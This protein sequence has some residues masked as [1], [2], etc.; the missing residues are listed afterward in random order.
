MARRTNSG[1]QSG[2]HR[3]LRVGEAI[4]RRLSEMFARGEIHDPAITA[5][6]ITVG[7]VRVTNDMRIATV[8]IMPLGGDGANEA[9]EAMRRRTGLIRHHVGKALTIKHI[10][11]LRFE[12]DDTF[13][14][15]DA[16]REL[17]KDERIQRDLAKVDTPDDDAPASDEDE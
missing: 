13:D 15:M 11:E 3:T 2:S 8:Y 9:L 5:L 17:F 6:S 12:L 16:T 7:E 4:R 10:P 1:G 14:R